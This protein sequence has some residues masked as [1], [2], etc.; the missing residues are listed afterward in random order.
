MFGIYSETT[1]QW[2][3]QWELY[4]SKSNWNHQL[5]NFTYAKSLHKTRAFSSHFHLNEWLITSRSMS[6]CNFLHQLHTVYHYHNQ[7]HRNYSR[8]ISQQISM[9]ILWL[10]VCKDPINPPSQAYPCLGESSHSKIWEQRTFS[11]FYLCR[12][13]HHVILWCF[14]NISVACYNVYYVT[15]FVYGCT[16]KYLPLIVTQSFPFPWAPT[17]LQPCV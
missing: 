13:V 2:F 7:Y 16:M 3:L 6:S 9:L 12:N 11:Q 4:H 14:L 15:W 5:L 1:T 17:D 10:A 8:N